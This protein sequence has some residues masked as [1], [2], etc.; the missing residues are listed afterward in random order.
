MKVTITR[1]QPAAC[2]GTWY[3]GWVDDYMFEAK[4]YDT[5]SEYGIDGGRI[6]KLWIYGAFFRDTVASYE[7][8]WDVEPESEDARDAL[9]AILAAL[10]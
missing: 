8:G 9:D 3:T 1:K 7:R 6:S 2:G 4:V 10:N 5:G